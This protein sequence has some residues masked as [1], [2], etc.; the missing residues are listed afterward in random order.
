MFKH[1]IYENE[2]GGDP[3]VITDLTYENLINY[4]KKYY[5]P[6]NSKFFTYGN[7]IFYFAVLLIIQGNFP[8]NEHLKA[9]DSKISSFKKTSVENV[10]KNIKPFES[11]KKIY[12]V[13]PFD[14][15]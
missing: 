10:E 15:C 11:P 14:P 2:S 7:F 5:H 9:I 12:D 8:L 4:H 13:F 3:A 6:T 1:T